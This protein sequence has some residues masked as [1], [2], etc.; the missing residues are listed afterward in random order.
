MCQTG[1]N[2][3]F[4]KVLYVLIS[5]IL[6]N[7]FVHGI[8]CMARAFRIFRILGFRFV[9]RLGLLDLIFRLDRLS[10]GTFSVDVAA[11]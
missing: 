3:E 1:C 11:R 4:D 9:L 10:L 7:I 6:S 5:F 8:I 2:S